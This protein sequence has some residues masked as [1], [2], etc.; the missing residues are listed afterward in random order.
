MFMYIHTTRKK[1]DQHANGP[2]KNIDRISF[3]IDDVC[4]KQFLIW[5][6]RMVMMIPL[7]MR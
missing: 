4:A 7:I 3:Q 2:R 1:D 6:I 5:V